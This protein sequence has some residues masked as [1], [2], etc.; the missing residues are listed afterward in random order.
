MN[1]DTKAARH[2]SSNEVVKSEKLQKT[3]KTYFNVP[4]T[5]EIH[6]TRAAI[7]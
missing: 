7:N 1:H 4:L 2:Q 5:V 3:N 6:A